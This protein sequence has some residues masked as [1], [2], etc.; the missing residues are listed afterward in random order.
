MCLACNRISPTPTSKFHWL[1]VIYF[2]SQHLYSGCRWLGS[3]QYKSYNQ[4]GA[5]HP[6][7]HLGTNILVHYHCSPA[8]VTHLK[9]RCQSILAPQ[10]RFNI[11]MSSYQYRKSHCGDKTVVR[12]SYLHNGIFYT[13]K[14][15][16]LNWIRALI[17]EWVTVAGLK[18]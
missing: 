10:A 2:Q 15:T 12:S 1:W 7:W 9:I 4:D 13:G 14:T 8:T 11:K 18:W 17:S 6:S 3:T 16:F 5:C